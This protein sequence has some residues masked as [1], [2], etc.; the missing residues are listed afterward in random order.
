MDRDRREQE[1]PHTAKGCSREPFHKHFPE[2]HALVL[3]GKLTV[4]AAMS[5]AKRPRAA[6]TITRLQEMELW[7]GSGRSGS[8]FSDD[9][10]RR[11]AWEENRDRL[12]ILFAHG[13]RRPQAW[14]RSRE[15]PFKYPGFNLEKS[16]LWASGLLGSAEQR[17]LEEDWYELFVRSL[18]PDFTFQGLSGGEAHIAAL[19]FEDVPPELCER[20]AAELPDAA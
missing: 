9:D 2:L 10:E 18:A 11:R 20:W 4:D 7:L 15:A 1:R 5:A 12:M 13:G 19:M 14:W 17:Q 16:S 8:A 3:D 6:P